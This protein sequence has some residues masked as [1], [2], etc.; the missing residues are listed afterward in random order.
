MCHKVLLP[1]IHILCLKV[2][3]I[4]CHLGKMG[5]SIPASPTSCTDLGKQIL[6][7]SPWFRYQYVPM[8][9]ELSKS[10]SL[11][12]VCENEEE[13]MF[14]EDEYIRADHIE[15]DYPSMTMTDPDLG[16]KF[17]I[18]PKYASQISRLCH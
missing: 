4:G 13:C 8:Y 1:H 11:S 15:F 7:E 17:A 6:L 5:V 3:T 16:H 12:V 18:H 9:P 2:Y 14:A 10:K